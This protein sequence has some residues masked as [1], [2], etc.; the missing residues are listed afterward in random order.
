MIGIG[1]MFAYKDL[2]FRIF[3][4]NKLMHTEDVTGKKKTGCKESSEK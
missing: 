1:K 3:V 4:E 2:Q